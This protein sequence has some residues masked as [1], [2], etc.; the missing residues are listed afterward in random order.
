VRS[1]GEWFGHRFY[2]YVFRSANVMR[3]RS[4]FR[5]HLLPNWLVVNLSFVIVLLRDRET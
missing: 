1:G 5:F 4:I 2:T 3:Q